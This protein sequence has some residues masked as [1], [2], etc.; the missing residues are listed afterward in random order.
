MNDICKKTVQKSF[1]LNDLSDGLAALPE[2]RNDHMFSCPKFQNI[3][4]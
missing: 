2:V 1:S 3:N 4:V